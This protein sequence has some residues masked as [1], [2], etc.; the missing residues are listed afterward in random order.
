MNVRK[1]NSAQSN[2]FQGGKENEK[3]RIGII[4]RAGNGHKPRC[5]RWCRVLGRL[6]FG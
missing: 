6:V 1:H 2:G 3:T 5:V 4:P